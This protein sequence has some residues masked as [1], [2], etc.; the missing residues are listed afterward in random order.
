LTRAGSYVAAA[1]LAVS[2]V[3]AA[4]AP[5]Q[6]LNKTVTMSWTTSSTVTPADGQARNVTNANTRTVYISGAGRSFLRMQLTSTRVSRGNRDSRSGDRGPD[7]TARGSVRF[8]PGKLIGVETFTNGARQFIAT[9]DSSYSSCTLSVVDA[10]AGNAAIMRRGPDGA[11]YKVENVTTG[12]Q[13]CS[14]QSGNAFAG[15]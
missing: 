7:D 6:L 3:H 15:Q 2:P 13:S 10:K 5:Q 8:E 1:V 4:G 14:I 11:M 9:F 12:A